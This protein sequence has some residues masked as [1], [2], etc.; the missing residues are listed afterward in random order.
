MLL[1]ENMKKKVINWFARQP[2]SIKLEL[3]KRQRDL[4]FELKKTKKIKHLRK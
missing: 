3:I 2:D 4:Y 1:S